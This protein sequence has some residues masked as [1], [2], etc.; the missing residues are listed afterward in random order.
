LPLTQ[1]P[2]TISDS[3]VTYAQRVVARVRGI[4]SS[5]EPLCAQSQALT[6]ELQTATE[7]LVR[8]DEAIER[9]CERGRSEPDWMRFGREQLAGSV[10]YL[11]NAHSVTERRLKQTSFAAKSHNESH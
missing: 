4:R 9:R 5:G 2:P 1:M 10:R 8:L 11:A 7:R 6:R 3:S